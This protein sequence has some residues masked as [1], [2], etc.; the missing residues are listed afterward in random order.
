MNRGGVRGQ[1]G[2]RAHHD[3]IFLIFDLY[4]ANSLF[5]GQPVP[6][7]DNRDLVAMVADV[8]GQQTPVGDVGVVGIEGIGMP[9]GSEPPIR[10]V[11]ESENGF[12]AVKASGLSGV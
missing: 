6:G 11:L 1:R 12:Y 3:G 5:G 4:Q 2:L 7:D 9:G 8:A 10:Y